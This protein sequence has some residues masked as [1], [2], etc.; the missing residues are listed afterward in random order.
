MGE[1]DDGFGVGRELWLG[2]IVNELV[3]DMG[4]VDDLVDR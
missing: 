1:V 2:N 4:R 3:D